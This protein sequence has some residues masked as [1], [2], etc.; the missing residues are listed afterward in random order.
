MLHRAVSMLDS[1]ADELIVDLIGDCQWNNKTKP[2]C[3]K[4][5]EQSAIYFRIKVRKVEVLV[6]VNLYARHF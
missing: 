2:Y 4:S 1:K 5:K 6:G 3:L